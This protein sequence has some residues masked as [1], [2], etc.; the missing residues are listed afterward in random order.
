MK[1]RWLVGLMLSLALAVSACTSPEGG[2]G[3]ETPT[4]GQADFYRDY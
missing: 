3:A 4:P 2:E 1:H